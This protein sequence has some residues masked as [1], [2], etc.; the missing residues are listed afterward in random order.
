[1]V[2]SDGGPGEKLIDGFFRG[3]WVEKPQ[4]TGTWIVTSNNASRVRLIDVE[5]RLVLWEERVANA[6]LPLFSPDRRSISVAVQA[7]TGGSRPAQRSPTLFGG[8]GTNT[9]AILDV[10]RQQRIIA[11]LPFAILFRASWVDNGTAL[12]VNRN[13]S[14]SHIVMFDRFWEP[15]R[16]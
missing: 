8:G 2:P 7:D 1:V 12:I 10:T 9:V 16:R 13:D 5:K 4:G 14:V 3:D 15:D 11:R 6:D